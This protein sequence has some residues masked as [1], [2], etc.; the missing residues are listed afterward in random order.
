M[1]N[2]HIH[3]LGRS[4]FVLGNLGLSAQLSC[5][6]QGVPGCSDYHQRSFQAVP[7]KHLI[8]VEINP[9][10]PPWGTQIICMVSPPLPESSFSWNWVLK[11]WPSG[12]VDKIQ[13]SWQQGLGAPASQGGSSPDLSFTV[14]FHK[15][16]K[17]SSL[18]FG[19]LCGVWCCCLLVGKAVAWGLLAGL[20]WVSMS[21]S[22]K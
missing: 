22:K 21:E 18:P 3:S 17:N 10:F 2:T 4:K 1:E 20:A 9:R 19:C 6:Q 16:E 14:I 8:F 5:P 13:Q 7:G 11:H 15:R 12:L